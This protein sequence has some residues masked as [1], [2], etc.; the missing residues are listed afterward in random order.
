MSATFSNVGSGEAAISLPSSR[1]I[2]LKSRLSWLVTN[3][4]AFPF[5]PA[6]AVLPMRWT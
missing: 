4:T 5:A 6:R 2:S 3:V 1:S